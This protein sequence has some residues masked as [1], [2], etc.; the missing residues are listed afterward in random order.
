M[1]Q[2]DEKIMAKA[3]QIQ[4]LMLDVDGVLTD[5]TLLYGPEGEAGKFFNVHDGTAIK[6]VQRAGLQVAW[7]TGRLS[8]PTVARAKELAI[9]HVIQDAKKKLPPFQ[10]FIARTITD[11]RTIAYMG[12]DLLDLPVLKRVGLSMAPADAAPE[13]LAKVDWVSARGGGKGAV[14]E[15]CELILK[16]RGE[17]DSPKS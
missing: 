15:A 10:E 2:P 17:G 8:K 12:D 9:D 4:V 3:A 1:A 14:R 11:P 6:W 5:G 16:A 13:V 7:L